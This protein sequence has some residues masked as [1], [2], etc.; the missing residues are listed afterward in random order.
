MVDKDIKKIE[1]ARKAKYKTILKTLKKQEKQLKKDQGVLKDLQKTKK[2]QES[3]VKSYNENNV[4][5]LV[6]K[7]NKIIDQQ[8]KDEQKK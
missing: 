5:N 4:T 7:Y 3:L 2:K 6:K 1:T 8:L